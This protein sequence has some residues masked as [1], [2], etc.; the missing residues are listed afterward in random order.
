MIVTVV[1]GKVNNM[2]LA[3]QCPRCRG[4]GRERRDRRRMCIRCG[5]SGVKP[6]GWAYRVEALTLALGDLVECPPT[7]YTHGAPALAT[8]IDLDGQPY[9][10][11]PLK[12]IIRKVEM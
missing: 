8:V 5:G 1:Y 11:K 4:E 6:E 10:G 7:P 9:P 3:R 12:K 2:D